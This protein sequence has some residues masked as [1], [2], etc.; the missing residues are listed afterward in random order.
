MRWAGFQA[1]ALV[2]VV[3]AVPAE[4]PSPILVPSPSVGVFPF[5]RTCDSAVSI[6]PNMR[7]AV[8]I[9]PLTL[10]GTTQRL[11]PSTFRS[12]EGRYT[13]IK[14]LA[15]VT[16][17]TDVT[18]T[19]PLRERESEFLLYNPAVRGNS[20]GFMIAEADAQV[21]FDACPGP[22]PR[23]NGGLLLKRPGCVE[24][25]VES[26]GW[27]LVTGSFPVGTRSPC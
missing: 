7:H 1:L 6:T 18:V 17:S 16:S 8:N 14:I 12:H 3:C 9:G 13:A 15:L 19:V 27:G 22:Y 23:Y 10:I 26:K 11:P 4:R 24:L 21:R 20:H 2:M 25:E 5:V